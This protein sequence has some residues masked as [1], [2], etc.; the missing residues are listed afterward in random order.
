MAQSYEFDVALSFAGEDRAFVDEVARSLKTRS[1][2]PF[3][4]QDFAIE[5]WGQNLYEYLDDL[6][7]NRA[8]FAVIFVSRF[9]ALKPWTNHERR[10]VQAR[11]LS[12]KRR[13]VVFQ[14]TLRASLKQS[15]SGLYR[16]LR[17][18]LESC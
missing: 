17:R 2:V 7:R 4:D 12:S 11:A 1:V 3:Y 15:V 5:L 16:A 13:S 6:Y 10:S 14:V 18:K 9:Y 8:R